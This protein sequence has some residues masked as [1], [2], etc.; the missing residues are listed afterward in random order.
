MSMYAYTISR[1]YFKY[2]TFLSYFAVFTM[3][4]NGGIVPSY[5]IN[6]SLLHLNDTLFI[7]FLPLMVNAFY[8]IVMRTFFRRS[9]PDAVIESAKLDGAHEFTILFR[10][11]MPMAKP[12]LATIGLFLVVELWNDWFHGLLYITKPELTSLQYLL[13]KIQNT[14]EFL[15]SSTTI[16]GSAHVLELIQ[17]IPT[18]SGRMALTVFVM[19][20]TLFAYP[21]FQRYFVRGLTVGAVKG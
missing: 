15:R 10:I 7:L 3:L 8:I 11:V 5:I 14:L 20:P 9:I 21:F 2:R 6:T 17:T 13:T 18:E 12:A 19:T 1:Q 4:F 16:S